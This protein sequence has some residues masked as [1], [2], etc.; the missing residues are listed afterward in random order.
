MDHFGKYMDCP[1]IQARQLL[2]LRQTP[3]SKMSYQTTYI[4][5]NLIHIRVSKIHIFHD[6]FHISHVT[7]RDMSQVGTCAKMCDPAVINRKEAKSVTM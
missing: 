4:D 5:L 1:L 7:G 3:V 6:V 2:I